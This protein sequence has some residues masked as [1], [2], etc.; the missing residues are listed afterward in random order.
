MVKLCP[1]STW[2]HCGSEK[3]L[4]HRVVA[5]ASTALEAGNVADSTL[6]AV[7]GLFSARLLAGGV[8]APRVNWSMSNRDPAAPVK[9]R[10]RVTVPGGGVVV[11]VTLTQFSQPPVLATV[12]VPSTG[13]VAEPV[14][15]ERVPPTP[16][17][18]TRAVNEVTPLRL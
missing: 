17:E 13:P 9:T 14:R 6:E 1:R 10:N 12:A 2:I 5:E 4:A 8:P 18:A 11:P 15:R 16:A 3:A 7:A